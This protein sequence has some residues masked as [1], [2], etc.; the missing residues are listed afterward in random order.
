MTS[1]E[2]FIRC[3]R[4]RTAIVAHRGAWHN[5]PENSI[6]ALEA[7]ISL[8]CEIMETDVQRSSDGILFPLHDSTLDRM[9][10]AR[11][12]AQNLTISELRGLRLRE[13]NGGADMPESSLTIPTLDE[14][15]EVAKGRIFLDL[16][17]KYP[18]LLD[19][20]GA[21]V[22]RHRMQD[23]INLKSKLRNQEDFAVLK[24]LEARH[25][26]IIMPQIRFGSDDADML[27]ELM[28]QLKSPMVEAKFDS[29]ETIALRADLFRSHNVS[30]WVNTLDAVACCGL[31]DSAATL[32]PVSVWGELLNAG[33]SIV[34]TD[35]PKELI[36]YLKSRALAAA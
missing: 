30:V 12:T 29:L 33:T 31:T 8:G 3:P 19:V 6:D 14:V 22:C 16:D 9:T 21:C 36:R 17:V 7:A 35:E 15:L 13:R 32:D 4:R 2:D 25:S 18:W 11:G 23:Q 26:T 5:A 34:Q 27:F 10:G 1:Y 24:A 20:T 28:T